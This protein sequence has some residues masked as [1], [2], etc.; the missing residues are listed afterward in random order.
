MSGIAARVIV[1]QGGSANISGIVKQLEVSGTS[2]VSGNVRSIRLRD[3]GR[4]TVEGTVGGI[5]GNGTAFL[6]AGSVVNGK[7]TETE[8]E[9]TYD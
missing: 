3:E 9:V 5:Y 2:H 1:D 4:V 6:E 8:R 7:P